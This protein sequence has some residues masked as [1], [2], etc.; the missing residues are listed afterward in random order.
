[1]IT[2]NSTTNKDSSEF[3]NIKPQFL[4]Y[5]LSSFFAF[6]L[7]ISFVYDT[8]LI[9]IAAG[10]LNLIMYFTTLKLAPDKLWYQH[11]GSLSLGIFMAQFIYQMHGMLEMHFFAFI[12]SIILIYYRNWKN[13]IPLATIVIVHHALFGYLQYAGMKEV[14]FTTADYMPLNTFII[15]ALLAAVIFLLCG[16]WSY[17]FEASAKVSL[18]SNLNLTKELARINKGIEFAE[19]ISEGNLEK[20]FKAEEDDKLGLALIKMHK[21][22][23]D[24]TEKN[25][26]ENFINIGIAKISELI[27]TNDKKI[28]DLSDKAISFLTKYINANQGSL[29]ILNDHEGDK[30][31][32]LTGCY[33]YGHKKYIKNTILPG[34]GLVGQCY[35]EKDLIILSD[36]PKDYIRITSGLGEALPQF[37]VICPLIVNDTVYG[38]MEFAC[39][40][41]IESYKIELLKKAGESL[42]AS[43]T[44]L[45]TSLHT[46]KL[47]HETQ[48]QAESMRAQEEELRQ[49]L[50]ELNTAQEELSRI[51]SI[52]ENQKMEMEIRE[53][54]FSLTTILSESDQYGTITMVNE[55]LCTVSKY[56]AEELI[57][58]PHNIFRHP[59]MPPALFKIFWSTIKRGETFN[60]IIKN[61]AKDGSHYWVDAYLVPVFD[62][63][64][65]IK[66]YVGA[67]YHITSDAFAE[68]MYNLQAQRLGLPS[69][70]DS[71]YA[72]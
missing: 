38:V 32:E 48:S 62:E 64:G 51:V 1:M 50:E 11:V 71:Q 63:N 6:G 23:F 3:M 44:S 19:D 45:R 36:V 21:Y 14:Y 59:D 70:A 37:V 12:G 2:S 65:N 26:N 13:Q 41:K 7:V 22:I 49:N 60:A 27:R 18:A 61:K 25:E 57:G 8:Y 17:E 54:V 40:K 31:L 34:E 39:F 72:Q 66:K 53:K 67:R 68:K 16:Y 69:L 24:A 35:L 43:I 9:A 28:D 58:K 56:T 20:E 30:H 47:L 10:A 33:A 29:F 55:K 15:H 5:F 4:S 42:A 46:Q 52:T